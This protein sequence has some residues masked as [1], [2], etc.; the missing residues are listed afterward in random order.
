MALAIWISGRLHCM[1]TLNMCCRAGALGCLTVPRSSSCTVKIQCRSY[2]R[3]GTLP[4]N[5][6]P[7]KKLNFDLQAGVEGIKKHFGLL[8]QEVVEKWVG[9]EGQSLHIHV[10]EKTKVIWEFRSTESLEQ[11]LVSSDQEVGGKSEA[12]LKLGRNNQTALFYGS[13]CTEV[14]R[15]GETRYSGYCTLRSKQQYASFNRKKQFD[16]S[17]FNTLH[18]RIRGDGRPWMINIASE[19][20]FSHQKNDL[21]NYFL[22]TRGGPYWQDIK[23]P[24]S[25]FF[26]SSQGRIQ[27][28]QYPLWLDKINTIGFTL[29]DKVDGPFQLEIDFIALCSD[30][31]HTE[32]FAYEKYKR[33]PEV[34]G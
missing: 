34:K 18:L 13:L 23:I 1:Q 3:P 22:F 16:W 11:W 2:R 20:Y 9:P 4:D 33:N 32:E 21:Y 26:L 8:K 25:K 29:G 6:P 24:F 17:R 12:Y 15:D 14:P 19:I 31:A 27:D 28:G 5:T 10:L 30:M 7:W